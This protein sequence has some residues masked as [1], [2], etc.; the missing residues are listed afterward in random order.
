M[1]SRWRPDFVLL[2]L[3]PLV[4]SPDVIRCCFS[5]A[6]LPFLIFIRVIQITKMK[7][8]IIDRENKAA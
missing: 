5:A 4:F 6:N 3:S 7:I 1:L 2:T 8:H